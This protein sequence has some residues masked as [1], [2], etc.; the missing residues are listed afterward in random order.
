MKTK[1][2]FLSVI[3]IFISVSSFSQGLT[4]GIK[5]GATLNKLT[6]RSFKEEFSFGYHVGAFAT[7]GMGGKLSLQPEVLFSQVSTDT[8]S[9]FSAVSQNLGFNKVKDVKLKYL[10][11]PI[12]LNYNL[13]NLFALQVGP[14][15]AI[16]IDQDKTLTQNGKEAFKTGDFSMVGG[17]QLKL[18]KFRVYGRYVIGLSDISDVPNSGEWK[19]Q[20]I[21]LGV[22]I[23]L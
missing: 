5:G 1:L 8:A 6:G 4:F 3:L 10:S 21:Q 12:L 18:V 11:I 23:A 20:S 13:S 19:N 22:G 14:Q 16:L 9:N 15:Y 17:L 2:I 7:L